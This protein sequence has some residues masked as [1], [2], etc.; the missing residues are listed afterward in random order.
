MGAIPLK[1]GI[2]GCGLVGSKRMQALGANHQLVAVADIDLGRAEQ[3]ASKHSGCA[4]FKDWR[5]VVDHAACDLIIVATTN[6]LLAEVA[7]AAVERRK[8]VLIEKPAARSAK[9]LEPLI[10]IASSCGVPVKVGFNHRFHPAFIKA[11][12]IWDSGEIGDLMY[13][14]GRYGHG[15]R[16]GYD[17][18][19]RADPRI[20]GGGEVLDQGVHLIDL[21]RWFAGEFSEIAGHVGTYFWDMTVEDNGFLMLKT[22]R[23]QVAWLHVSCTEWKNLF[24]FEI[25]GRNGK[26]QI[27]GLGGS[28]GTERLTHYKML[29]QM[30]PPETTAWDFPGTDNSWQLELNYFAECTRNGREPQGNLRDAHA[31]LKIIDALYKRGNSPEQ[32]LEA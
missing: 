17:K 12:Q 2:V 15:G 31:V 21:S 22:A 9:E 27:D 28:Y 8:P 5:A 29:P 6:D 10:Q 25:F 19:W 11:R 20:A 4:S 23:Q 16:I 14:R 26:L 13:I 24:S 18:E 3:M 32:A 1:V 7:T 30:G